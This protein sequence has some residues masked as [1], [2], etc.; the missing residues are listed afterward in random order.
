MRKI[1]LPLSPRRTT[2][3][4][5]ICAYGKANART[6][7]RARILLRSAA[8]ASIAEIA[9]EQFT[10]EA[11]VSN[12]RQ[13]YRKGGVERV[14]Q[15]K[16]Q[17]NRRHALTGE[18]EALLIAIAC[19]P[20][21]EGHDHW[22]LRMLRDKL[23]ELKVVE[24]ID[25]TTIG[26]VLK[27]ELKPWQREHWCL[28][29]LDAAFLAA[30]EDVLDVYALPY[31]PAIP[32]VCLDEN[33]VTLH[34][35]TNPTL[36][37]EPGKPERVDY[38]YERKGTANL[39]VM[40]EPLAG[41]RHV[42]VTERRTAKDY[43]RQLVWLANER[44]PDATKICLIQDNLNTHVLSNL[45]L[46]CPPEEARRLSK[47]FEIHPTPK[48]GSW[49]DMAEIEIGILNEDVCPVGLRVGKNSVLG[50]RHWKRREI[51]QWLVF[52]GVLP[53]QMLALNSLVSMKSCCNR[54]QIHLKTTAN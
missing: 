40:V 45:Y 52:A 48:H 24:S 13:H 28:S 16:Q 18:G 2:G 32:T 27:N 46:V 37:V 6:L 30:M 49:L 43:A 54:I 17:E 38:E 34:G 1:A 31:D 51:R 9:K 44:Y 8:G 21:P 29:K 36:P 4:G 42:E 19:S 26:H 11:N 3:V 41:W 50:F 25:H 15:D 47:R 20:V 53:L 14:L 33:L 22:T 35:D 23:I 5:D 10:S 7:T 12:V 39:F